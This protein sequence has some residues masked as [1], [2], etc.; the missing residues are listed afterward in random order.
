VEEV[1]HLTSC[2]L[3]IKVTQSFTDKEVICDYVEK[4]LSDR[5]RKEKYQQ[6]LENTTGLMF[7]FKYKGTMMW[8]DTIA[9]TVIVLLVVG[10]T[11]SNG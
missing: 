3:A 4:L 8:R 1:T 7:E 5:D 10:T 6:S 11:G 2:G 9:S